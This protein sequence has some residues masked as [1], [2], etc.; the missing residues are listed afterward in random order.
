MKTQNHGRNDSVGRTVDSTTLRRRAE[1]KARAAGDQ[2]LEALSPEA[3]RRLLHEL[4]VR[5][6]ELE[7]QNE[8]LRTQQQQLELI[9]DNVPAYIAYADA[10]LNLLHTN[11]AMA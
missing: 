4:R 7:M 3:A 9:I 10:D 5:Q 2:D 6:I 1:E 8:E 11:R